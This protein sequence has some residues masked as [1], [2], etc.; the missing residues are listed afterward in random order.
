MSYS[1][2]LKFEATA[3]Q[4]FGRCETLLFLYWDL[5]FW[6]H[7]VTSAIKLGPQV[8]HKASK[9][10]FLLLSSHT[11]TLHWNEQRSFRQTDVQT[12][13]CSWETLVINAIQERW[14][15]EIIWID[16]FHP[17]RSNPSVLRVLLWCGCTIIFIISAFCARRKS[18]SGD[19]AWTME[20]TWSQHGYDTWNM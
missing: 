3:F 17:V 8:G 10:F 4:Y 7:L 20:H 14:K 19:Q 16:S 9:S 12:L 15:R 1:V 5:F 6:A 2:Q 18:S 11:H 13:S